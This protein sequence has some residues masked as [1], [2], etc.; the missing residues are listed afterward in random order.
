MTDDAERWSWPAPRYKAPLVARARHVYGIP[1]RSK[2]DTFVIAPP[3]WS[4]AFE[5]RA[6]EALDAACASCGLNQIE[7]LRG[8]Q[9]RFLIISHEWILRTVA[10]G[11][12]AL[13]VLSDAIEKDSAPPS[14]DSLDQ[15]VSWSGLLV[16]WSSGDA[17]T[18]ALAF[19][20][21]GGPSDDIG[22]IWPPGDWTD[23][24][25]ESIQTIGVYVWGDKREAVLEALDTRVGQAEAMERRSRDA[26]EP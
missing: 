1:R 25:G 19:K 16:R 11:Q 24:R 22:Q 4:A 18:R 8:G 7:A 23:D 9:Q 20:R 3:E 5:R 2:I 15:H 12:E 14:S 26:S 6:V 10:S 21:E 17:T 13:D